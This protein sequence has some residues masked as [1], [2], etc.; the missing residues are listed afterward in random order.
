[1]ILLSED[2]VS[3]L[4]VTVSK[5][6]GPALAAAMLWLNSRTCPNA[7]ESCP[8]RL[9][10]FRLAT[11]VGEL[12]LNGGCP[13]A[14]LRPSAVAPAW[15]VV[16]HRQRLVGNWRRER[17]LRARGIRLAKDELASGGGVGS[18][19]EGGEERQVGDDGA[20]AGTKARTTFWRPPYP[21]GR[22]PGPCPFGLAAV[23]DPPM[24][25]TLSPEARGVKSMK[26]LLAQRGDLTSALTRSHPRAVELTSGT[27]RVPDTPS[28]RAARCA[29]AAQ[30]RGQA[31]PRSRAL[32]SSGSTNSEPVVPS[33]LLTS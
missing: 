13:L 9:S 32:P 21:V 29:P 24:W 5:G 33:E 18:A 26:P 22:R 14:T 30:R 8:S 1:M 27:R 25:A 12:T 20:V 2:S 7:V 19:A 31:G 28:R 11:L 10:V 16:G 23:G 3:P 4:K 17:A 6:G 15:C